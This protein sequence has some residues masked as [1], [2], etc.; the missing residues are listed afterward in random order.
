MPPIRIGNDLDIIE[1]VYC[2]VCENPG[3]L[4]EDISKEFDM[5]E[6]KI[7]SALEELE[8]SGL[9]EFKIARM[10]PTVKKSYPVEKSVLMKEK[11]KKELKKFLQESLD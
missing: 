3:K 1:K 2:V 4:T 10:S 5:P 7:N 8:R 9:V 11:F 6:E